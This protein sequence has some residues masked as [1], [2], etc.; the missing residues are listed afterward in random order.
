[1]PEQTKEEKGGVRVGISVQSAKRILCWTYSSL[2]R[3]HAINQ[4]V[5]Q[6]TIRKDN[7]DKKWGLTT[8]DE[9]G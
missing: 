8:D 5:N 7:E 6:L 4:P 2:T 3:K 1:L 9:V